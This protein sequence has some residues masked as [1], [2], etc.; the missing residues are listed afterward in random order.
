MIRFPPMIA[1]TESR[2]RVPDELA[3]V[4][5]HVQG[6]LDGDL[7]LRTLAGVSHVS[8]FHFH[9]TF[10]ALV[11][12]T[13]KGYVQRVR[14]ERAAIR[15]L[16]HRG[17]VW[18]IALDSGFR[19]HETFCRAFKERFGVSP[20]SY[21]CRIPCGARG[22]RPR[23]NHAVDESGRGFKL[24]KTRVVE[25]AETHLACL[26]YVGP[27]EKA[28][29]E[30]WDR[31]LAWAGRSGVP[32]PPVLFGIAHDAPG[33]TAQNRLR[34][35]AGIRIPGPRSLRGAIACQLLD[36]GPFALTTHLGHYRTLARGFQT[37]FARLRRLSGYDVL[38]LPAVEVYRTTRINLE[39]EINE[40]DIYIP[41]RRR[42]G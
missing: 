7:S 13:V 2:S 31:L 1:G 28:P 19:N 38:G 42:P 3:R 40:T 18:D 12:E 35:D 39:S 9:R 26:R 5:I 41:L 32:G 29:A 24:S 16:L 30:L 27:Y 22:D 17:A 20:R 8:P 14:L 36:A 10:R 21:R 33:I 6:H 4:L 23:G 11:G 25:L 15:L 37:I 34:F